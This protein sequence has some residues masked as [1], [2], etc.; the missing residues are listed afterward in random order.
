MVPMDKLSG[1]DPRKHAFSL[2][3][4]F[5]AFAFKGNVIDLAVGVIIGAAF[6]KI[7]DSLVKHVL[8]PL[9]AA[10]VPGNE[11][12]K[13]LKVSVG[14]SEVLYGE[15]LAE[16][17]NFLIVALALFVFVVKFLGWVVRTKQKEA[18]APPPPTKDQELLAEIRDL[19]RQQAG[20]A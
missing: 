20:K 2:F 13:G 7:V 12:Y 1:I 6:G 3:E 19:L 10:V 16:V 14:G 5:K 4:E 11:G 8:M 15:F 9:V 18:A 17:V